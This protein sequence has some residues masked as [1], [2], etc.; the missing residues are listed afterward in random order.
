[1]AAV[2]GDLK[3]RERPVTV[4]FTDSIRVA[5]QTMQNARTHSVL[6]EP[7][8]GGPWRI[9]TTSDQFTAEAYGVPDTD[10][11]GT[12]SNEVIYFVTP[13]TPIIDCKAKTGM[14]GIHH[15]PVFSDS[16]KSKLIGM[17]SQEDIRYE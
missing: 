8:V 1:M 7:H 9:F 17:V 3:L 12:H 16:R 4:K 11:V 13:D 5:I 2:V 10:P 6:V 14:F 15:L